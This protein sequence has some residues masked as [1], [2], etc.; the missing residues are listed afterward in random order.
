MSDLLDVSRLA[1]GKLRLD[2]RPTNLATV[3]RTALDII[4]PIATAKGVLISTK[5]DD[6]GPVLGDAVR[7]QQVVWNLLANA[8]KFTP[9]GGRVA[10]TLEREDSTLVL[11]VADTGEGIAPE[12]LPFVFDRFR[13]GGSSGSRQ[14][15]GLGLGLAIVQDIVGRH[16]G[17][18]RAESGGTGNGSVFTVVLPA[19]HAAGSA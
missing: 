10:V 18:V 12:F 13:Q 4:A 1:M 15:G 5:F 8:V 7:L 3:T 16:G 9:T 17:S 14:V 2:I 11:R 6:A 19:D